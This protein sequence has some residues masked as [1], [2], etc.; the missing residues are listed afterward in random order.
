MQKVEMY[1]IR[2]L[3]RGKG[4]LALH[5]PFLPMSCFLSPKCPW[6]IMVE[7]KS[8]GERCACM[9][10]SRYNVSESKALQEKVECDRF[11]FSQCSGGRVVWSGELITFKNIPDRAADKIKISFLNISI[12]FFYIYRD[13]SPIKCFVSLKFILLWRNLEVKYFGRAWDE[14]LIAVDGINNQQI[15]SCRQ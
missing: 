11:V 1:G 15:N 6:H 13:K 7:I 9:W 12:F 4:S 2:E 8:P 10:V 14:R 3:R 5:F